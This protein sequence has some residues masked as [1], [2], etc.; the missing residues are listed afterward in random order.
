[1]PDVADAYAQRDLVVSALAHLAPRQRAAVVL[2]YFDD[3]SEAET[4]VALGCS[5]GTVKSQTSRA[6]ARLRDLIP[7]PGETPAHRRA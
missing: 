7:A 1:M 4:A 6:I 2:R 5:V 3:L